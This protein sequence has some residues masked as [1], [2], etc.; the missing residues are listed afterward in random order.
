MSFNKKFYLLD[1][2][3]IFILLFILFI[4]LY[5]VSFSF[6]NL[7]YEKN[8]NNKKLIYDICYKVFKPSWYNPI[9]IYSFIFL[10]KWWYFDKVNKN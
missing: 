8:Y 2:N 7:I 3:K 4:I 10:P 6:N 9:L 1:K 5:L